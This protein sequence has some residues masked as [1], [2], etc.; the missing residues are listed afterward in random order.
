MK[1]I[2]SDR[3]LKAS[4][5]GSITS[6]AVS[7]RWRAMALA[8]PYPECGTYTADQARCWPWLSGQPFKLSPLRSEAVWT[9][10]SS[11][12]EL[13]SLE[14]SDTQIYEPYVRALLGTASYFCEIVVLELIVWTM[15]SLAVSRRW[16]AMALATPYSFS[17]ILFSPPGVWGSRFTGVPPHKKHPPPSDDQRSLGIGPL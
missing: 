12:L 13:S 1:F 16:R 15:T 4:R 7:R 9:V 11:P 6:L 10:T 14:L 5:E 2:T 17:P 3:K 8:T